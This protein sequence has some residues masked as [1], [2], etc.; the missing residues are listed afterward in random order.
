[1]KPIVPQAREMFVNKTWLAHL[2]KA[3]RRYESWS[4][5]RNPGNIAAMRQ[6]MKQMGEQMAAAASR[7]LVDCRIS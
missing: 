3:A 4:E 5:S 1:M 2:E 7:A 6:F